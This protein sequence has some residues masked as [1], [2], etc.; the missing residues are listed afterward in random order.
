MQYQ[1]DYLMAHPGLSEDNNLDVEFDITIHPNGCDIDRALVVEEPH[2]VGVLH[3]LTDYTSTALET[4]AVG[5]D[6]SHEMVR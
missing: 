6:V 1:H 5:N 3:D 2:S 4:T